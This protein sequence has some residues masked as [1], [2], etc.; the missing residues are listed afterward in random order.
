[1]KAGGDLIVSLDGWQV[2]DL[3]GLVVYLAKNK[4]PGVVVFLTVLQGEKL[5]D[6][7]CILGIHPEM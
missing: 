6:L 5:L 3:N 1:M 2:D 4:T 7:T